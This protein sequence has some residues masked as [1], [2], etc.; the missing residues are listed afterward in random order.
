[1]LSSFPFSLLPESDCDF[2]IAVPDGL[3]AAGTALHRA[4]HP[5]AGDARRLR[6]RRVQ[7]DVGRRQG[8]ATCEWPSSIIDFVLHLFEV[9]NNFT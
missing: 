4:V 1:M 3:C 2:H 8:D 7:G 9:I 5:L 6:P